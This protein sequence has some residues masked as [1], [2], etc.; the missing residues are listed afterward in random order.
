MYAQ[1]IM[2]S[3][4]FMFQPFSQHDAAKCDFPEFWRPA[5]TFWTFINVQ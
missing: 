2:L 5:F 3:K 4:N 1:K